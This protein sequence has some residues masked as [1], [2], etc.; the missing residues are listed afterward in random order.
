MPRA[1]LGPTWS[2][3]ERVALT[4]RVVVVAGCTGQVGRAVAVALAGQGNEV[5]GLARFRDPTQRASLE[6]A[7]VTCHAVDL[8]DP[9]FSSVPPEPDHL[10]NFAV[11]KSGRWHV[12][13]AA[14]ADAIGLMMQACGG[15]Q[16][17]LHCSSTAVYAP[18][19]GEPMSEDS[20]LGQDH[21][22]HVMPTYS[23]A[24]TAAEAVA[25]FASRAFEVP[26]T[27][28]R[29]CVPYG[30]DVGWPL[31]HLLMAKEGQDIPV[32]SD[33]GRY[34]LIHHDDI[35]E[36]IP[37]MLDAASVPATVLNWGSDEVV[38]IEEWTCFMCDEAGVDTPVFEATEL[39]IPSA[40]V[41]TTLS[42]GVLGPCRVSWQDGL[43]RLAHSTA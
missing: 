25:R 40:V 43:R 14:N 32:H 21:H 13:L 1:F 36:Q 33:G 3:A 29:L 7:G 39:T 23:T 27:I 31:F 41:D 26:T 12:D 17:V 18:T 16:S 42:R 9:D 22:R 8:V 30:D 19:G 34:N 37:A 20:P 15:A 4:D 24:K 38:S 6:E 5:H 10:L 28:A 35:V 11:A 2:P